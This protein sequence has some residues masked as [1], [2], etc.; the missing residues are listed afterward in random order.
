MR[1]KQRLEQL[2]DLL[3]WGKV[4]DERD[5]LASEDTRG[6]EEVWEDEDYD[7]DYDLSEGDESLIETLCTI[8]KQDEQ[9]IEMKEHEKKRKQSTLDMW[10]SKKTNS[11]LSN[12]LGTDKGE[13]VATKEVGAQDDDVDELA[14][15][16]E[17]G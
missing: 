4:E 10:I 11:N 5:D 2:K 15:D 1:R 8:L 13:E 14:A 9:E 7:R 12:S 17:G 3:Q 6:E 16:A